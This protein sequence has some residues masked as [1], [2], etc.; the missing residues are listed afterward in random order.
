MPA[1]TWNGGGEWKGRP[2][3]PELPTD[4]AL[5]FYLFASYLAAPQWLFPQAGTLGM[6]MLT[7]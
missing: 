4:S 1:F 2:W 7:R 3:S 5:I 6:T